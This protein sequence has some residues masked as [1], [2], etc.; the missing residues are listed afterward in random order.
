MYW[1]PVEALQ[2][3]AELR[4]ELDACAKQVRENAGFET[5]RQIA[6]DLREL[7]EQAQA[8][9]DSGMA[10]SQPPQVS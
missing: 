3:I 4:A 6:I 7:S 9:Y 5:L 1:I 8:A 2:K 10:V